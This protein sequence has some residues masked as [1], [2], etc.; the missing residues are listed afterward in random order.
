MERC[1]VL[2]ATTKPFL[3]LFHH[4]FIKMSLD[5]YKIDKD[6][7]DKMKKFMHLVNLHIQKKHQN[8]SRDKEKT[9]LDMDSFEVIENI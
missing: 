3:V 5:K 1:F 2:I 8:Y 9:T 7:E 6:V 4:G